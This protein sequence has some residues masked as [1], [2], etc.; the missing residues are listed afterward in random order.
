MALFFWPSSSPGLCQMD[1]YG[2]EPWLGRMEFRISLILVT[3]HGL[4]LAKV[5]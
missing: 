5:I 3:C 4:E 2:E 1:G